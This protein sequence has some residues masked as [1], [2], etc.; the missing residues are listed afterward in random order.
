[1]LLYHVIKDNLSQICAFSNHGDLIF[2]YHYFSFPLFLLQWTFS[3]NTIFVNKNTNSIF[4]KIEL[5][6]FILFFQ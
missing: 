2:I 4:N 5:M 1:M 6:S 3:P